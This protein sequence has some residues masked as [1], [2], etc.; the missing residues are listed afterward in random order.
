MILFSL[1][2]LC[3]VQ[4]C[5]ATNQQMHCSCLPA[6]GQADEACC[7]VEG[8]APTPEQ[9]CKPEGFQGGQGQQ[10]DF[11]R[12]GLWGQRYKQHRPYPAAA[13]A[14][15]TGGAAGGRLTDGAGAWGS[16]SV[17]R[18]RVAC[19]FCLVLHRGVSVVH[20]S[21]GHCSRGEGVSKTYSPELALHL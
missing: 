9:S 19:R 11:L 17:L 12:Q 20:R 18:S 7:V 13:A 8:A 15:A 3:T 16:C 10:E 21:E 4:R 2:V 5:P 14:A 6:P 1:G